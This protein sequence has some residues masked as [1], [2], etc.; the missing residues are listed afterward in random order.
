MSKKSKRNKNKGKKKDKEAKKESKERRRHKKAIKKAL[1]YEK[2]DNMTPIKPV[3][4]LFATAVDYRT[5]RLALRDPD[6][7]KNAGR[8]LRKKRKDVTVDMQGVTFDGKDPVAII[9]FFKT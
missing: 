8:K 2:E 1:Q 9:N 7:N 6:Y 3:N 5:Y 4:S